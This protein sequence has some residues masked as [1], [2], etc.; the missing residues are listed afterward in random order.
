MRFQTKSEN[1]STSTFVQSSILR[2]A[3]LL[4]ETHYITQ[5]TEN[6]RNKSLSDERKKSDRFS[7][8]STLLIQKLRECPWDL[9]EENQ[10]W[11]KKKKRKSRK[12]FPFDESRNWINLDGGKKQPKRERDDESQES[13]SF[14]SFP[15]FWATVAAA[16]LL[17]S[18]FFFPSHFVSRLFYSLSPIGLSVSDT[19]GPA[20][21]SCWRSIIRCE[22]L[23]ACCSHF[24]RKLRK[25]L[26]MDDKKIDMEIFL[27]EFI[28]RTSISLQ[29]HTYSLFYIPR[30]WRQRKP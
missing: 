21:V 7:Y 13:F 26:L 23:T 12:S 22:M 9:K 30:A 24:E 11:E 27:V 20:G 8:C 16:V 18:Y 29:E 17:Y 19:D 4:S 28:L 5:S 10:Q 14:F 1:S 2:A 3:H 25:E 6:R 15:H